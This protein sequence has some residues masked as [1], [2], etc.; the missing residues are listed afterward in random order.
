MVVLIE[1]RLLGEQAG[2]TL[3]EGALAGFVRPDD[4]HGEAQGLAEV[5]QGIGKGHLLR[6][7]SEKVI[8]VLIDLS[9][10]TL[11]VAG[12]VREEQLLGRELGVLI[13]LVPIFLQVVLHFL[14]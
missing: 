11:D 10:P 14:L 12:S 5:D 1:L 2:H 7:L 6:I 4:C 13:Q 9:D 3:D 8:E